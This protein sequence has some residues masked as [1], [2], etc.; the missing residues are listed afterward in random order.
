[1]GLHIWAW[2]SCPC[3]ALLWQRSWLC[4]GVVRREKRPSVPQVEGTIEV[5]VNWWATA[6]FL[7]LCLKGVGNNTCC[8]NIIRNLQNQHSFF[9][10][11]T[12][13][14]ADARPSHVFSQLLFRT[15]RLPLRLMG[16][17]LSQDWHS[18]PLLGRAV[19][20]S[21]LKLCQLMG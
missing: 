14:L 15:L 2:F 1:M 11:N 17:N 10:V 6:L 18:S 7:R 21:A 13:G 19:C 12:K 8:E 4:G 20:F 3:P 5:R 16:A 9:L